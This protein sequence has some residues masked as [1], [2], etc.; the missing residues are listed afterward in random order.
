M[1][2][3]GIG[4]DDVDLAEACLDIGDK[5]VR[6]IRRADVVEM[7]FGRAASGENIA[8]GLL[9]FLLE[10]VGDDD[11]VAERCKCLCCRLADTDARPRDDD[12]PLFHTVHL[13]VSLRAS[14]RRNS[15]RASGRRKGSLPARPETPRSPPPL[16]VRRSGRAAIRASCVRAILRKDR[17]P[18]AC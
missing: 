5:P 2:D 16:P 4:D 9:A 11:M 3:A 8:N 15:A 13:L 1:G 14:H 6:G 18:A 17:A 12:D 7:E 10:D